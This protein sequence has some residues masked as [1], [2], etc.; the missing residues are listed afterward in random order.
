[1]LCL[2]LQASGKSQFSMVVG[3]GALHVV[4]LTRSS[5][6]LIQPIYC[7]TMS[8]TFFYVSAIKF[9]VKLV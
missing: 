6:I 5:D 2:F 3:L 4:Q 8:E 9:R 7:F 1:M